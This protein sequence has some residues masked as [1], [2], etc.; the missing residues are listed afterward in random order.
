M[1]LKGVRLT[2]PPP[3]LNRFNEWSQIEPFLFP[4]HHILNELDNSCQL[5]QNSLFNF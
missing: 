3:E 4:K 5:K 1:D 2:E